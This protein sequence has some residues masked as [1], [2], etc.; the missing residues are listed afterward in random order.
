MLTALSVTRDHVFGDM[1]VTY[2][3]KL[4][5]VPVTTLPS[6]SALVPITPFVRL[7]GSQPRSQG[8]LLLT[9]SLG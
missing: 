1:R 9:P 2:Q 3:G 6:R 8:P 4:F 7:V 5:Y